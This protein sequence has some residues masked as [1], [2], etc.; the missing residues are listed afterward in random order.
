MHKKVWNTETL[1]CA[2]LIQSCHDV[3]DIFSLCYSDLNHIIYF[4]SQN[5]SIQV[6][7]SLE[8]TFGISNI[9]ITVRSGTI[10][11]ILKLMDQL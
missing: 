10:L 5:T 8:S 3:G 6:N 11:L 7:L 1:K 9:L 2:Y 4:G